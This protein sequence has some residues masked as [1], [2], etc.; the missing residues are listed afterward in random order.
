MSSINNSGA[1]IYP[2]TSKASTGV[3]ERVLERG[4]FLD[5]AQPSALR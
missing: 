3:R 4:F 1:I 5:E 2:V